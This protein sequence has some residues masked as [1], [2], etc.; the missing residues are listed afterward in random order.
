MITYYAGIGARDTPPLICS[1]M[2]QIGS[3]LAEE[4][5]I[6]RSGGADGADRAFEKGCDLAGGRKE[7]F[8]PEKGYNGNSS[9]LFTPPE[10]AF[11]LID[12]IWEDLKNRTPL[13]R[14]LFARNCLQILGSDLDSASRV[15]I[16]WTR[17]GTAVGGTGKAIQIAELY[18]IPVIN[19]FDETQQNHLVDKTIFLQHLRDAV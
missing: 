10:T 12:E 5:W 16:C 15:V 2:E 7:I 17:N 9:E 14:A 8:L 4:G 13:V 19:L 18:K 6:L 11:Q 3:W 1:Y